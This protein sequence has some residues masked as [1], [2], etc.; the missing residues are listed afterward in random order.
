MERP[1]VEVRESCNIKGDS[2]M[3]ARTLMR[4]SIEFSYPDHQLN[5]ID[6]LLIQNQK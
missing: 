1:S 6:D 3:Q 4:E 5:I 2:V